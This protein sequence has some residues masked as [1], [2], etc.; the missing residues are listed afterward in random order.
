MLAK[1]MLE[2]VLHKLSEWVNL[3]PEYHLTLHKKEGEH[4]D[5]Y[6]PLAILS[7]SRMANGTEQ[8]KK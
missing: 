6:L 8:V 2:G 4:E 5:L 1:P 3:V 7:Q